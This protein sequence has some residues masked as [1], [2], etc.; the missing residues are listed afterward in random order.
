MADSI[1]KESTDSASANAELS[2]E[3]SNELLKTLKEF[4]TKLGEMKRNLEPLKAKVDKSEIHTSKG[5]SFL[6]LKYRKQ[7]QTT[8]KKGISYMHTHT[9]I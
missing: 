7:P 2:T 3:E 5:V 9:H 4:N 6:E 1:T 8:T